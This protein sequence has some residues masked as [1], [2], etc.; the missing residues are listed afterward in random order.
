MR[1]SWPAILRWLMLLVI[2]AGAWWVINGLAGKE[3]APGPVG[4]AHAEN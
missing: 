3:T 1:R 2:L 4:D